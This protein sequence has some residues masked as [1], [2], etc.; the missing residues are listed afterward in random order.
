MA[1]ERLLKSDNIDDACALSRVQVFATPWTVAR[2]APSSM[3]FYRQES[4]SGLPFPPPGDLPDPG[5]E[6]MSPVSPALQ[7]D[8]LPV[9]LCGKPFHTIL[10]TFLISV[11]QV[12]FTSD[13]FFHTTSFPIISRIT[14]KGELTFTYIFNIRSRKT[15]WICKSKQFWN[16]EDS[17]RY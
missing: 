5:I 17:T 7:E 4:W 12:V 16:Q 3:E 8:S 6:P 10:K 2:Q 11:L 14:N 1:W 13:L 15:F 9:E